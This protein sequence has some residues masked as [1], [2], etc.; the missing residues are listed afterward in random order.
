[1]IDSCNSSGMWFFLRR[2]T[3]CL[4]DVLNI[5]VETHGFGHNGL[6]TTVYIEKMIKCRHN[7][8]GFSIGCHE[9]ERTLTWA[10]VLFRRFNGDIKQLLPRI[11]SMRGRPQ[12]QKDEASPVNTTSFGEIAELNAR[13][14]I[15]V[16]EIVNYK[17]II[18]KCTMRCNTTLQPTLLAP[19]ILICN[20]CT[21]SFHSSF[22]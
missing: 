14:Q 19:S 5:V 12:F 1:M 17:R 18:N 6:S 9:L 3:S 22:L 10:S 16:E 2:W 21:R 15:A 11:P 13:L 4:L 7:L 20:I 8:H